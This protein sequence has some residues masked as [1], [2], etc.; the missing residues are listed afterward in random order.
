[1]LLSKIVDLSKLNISAQIY[2]ACLTMTAFLVISGHIFAFLD[3]F[4]S[5]LVHDE[6]LDQDKSSSVSFT[7]VISHSSINSKLIGQRDCLI[8][9]S[10]SVSFVF[11]SGKVIT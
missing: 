9:T 3:L 5:L 8:I 11:L 6:L 10:Q 1:M 7:G 4:L 2:T